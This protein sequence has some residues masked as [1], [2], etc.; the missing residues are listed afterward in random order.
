[1]SKNVDLSKFTAAIHQLSQLSGKDLETVMKAE[2]S[3]VLEIC[4][5]FT[6][7]ADREKIKAQVTADTEWRFEHNDS[8]AGTVYKTKAGKE[9]FTNDPQK[10]KWFMLSWR[11]PA[12]VWSSYLRVVSRNLQDFTSTLARRLQAALARRGLT[13]ATWL[14]IASTIGAPAPKAPGFVQQA[15]I[16]EGIGSGQVH[17]AA[18]SVVITATNRSK[19]LI[20]QRTGQGIADRAVASRA[21]FIDTAIRKG[22][23]SSLEKRAKSFPHLFKK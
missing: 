8:D 6:P 19:A 23:L 22:A 18:K 10:A 15:K 7:V 5:R 13:K 21:K 20:R 14:Q 17:T 2:T 1:M 16:K 3:K 4:V 12:S 9:W 11:L